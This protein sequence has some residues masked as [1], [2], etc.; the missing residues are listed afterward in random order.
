MPLKDIEVFFLNTL[1]K[2]TTLGVAVVFITDLTFFP[3][4]TVSVSIDVTILLACIVAYLIRNRHPL[5]SIISLNAIVLS[6]MVYQC[7]NVPTNTTTSLSIILV[8]GFIHSVMLRGKIMWALHIITYL[9]VIAIFILQFQNPSLRFSKAINDV[10]TVAVTYSILYGILALATARLKQSY[11][12]IHRH[13]RELNLHLEQIVNERTE[14]VNQQ[15]EILLK[16]SYTNAHHLR[17]P[18]ARLLGLGELYKLENKSNPEFIIE[19]MVD[20]ANEI[21][22][23]VKQ[24]NIDLSVKA[25]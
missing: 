18:V 17:G 4:D 24:I 2:I 14:K 25:E 3:E 21:D 19:K 12:G 1:L 10:I 20:Q 22:T 8:V 9:A 16:Y 6:A 13:L 5:V 23:V 15:N 7:L 11:D